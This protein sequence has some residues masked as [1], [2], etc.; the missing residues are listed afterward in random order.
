[1]PTSCHL[2]S[3]TRLQQCAGNLTDIAVVVPD[4]KQPGTR[5]RACWPAMNE[6]SRMLAMSVGR[7][8]NG[9]S[10]GRTFTPG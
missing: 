7:A 4:A 10:V 8:S 2:G 5:G 6:G 9:G 3:T 1:M